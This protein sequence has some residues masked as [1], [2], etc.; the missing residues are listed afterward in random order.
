M[1]NHTRFSDESVAAAQHAHRDYV[2]WA[3]ATPGADLSTRLAQQHYQALQ[4]RLS[5]E[6]KAYFSVLVNEFH[7]PS[8]SGRQEVDDDGR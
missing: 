2:V 4:H 7:G 1:A 8:V 6:G 3:Y 5:P